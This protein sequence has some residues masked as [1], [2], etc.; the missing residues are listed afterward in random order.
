M[1]ETVLVVMTGEG[2]HGC[3]HL[4][5]GGQGCCCDVQEGAHNKGV[6]SP[7]VR[8]AQI[9]KHYCGKRGRGSPSYLNLTATMVGAGLD[10]E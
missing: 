4:V 2:R 1:Q 3:W 7:N 5:G 9:E 8:S 10:R 6:T